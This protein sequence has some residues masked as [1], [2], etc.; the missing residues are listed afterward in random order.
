VDR[1]ENLLR[2]SDRELGNT[3]S[4]L[5]V[6]YSDNSDGK[7]AVLDFGRP[8]YALD[9]HRSNGISLLSEDRVDSLYDQ[10]EIQADFRHQ[11][12]RYSVFAGISD[13]LHDG[14]VRRYKLGLA[15]DE[16][17][18]GPGTDRSLPPAEL[19]PDRKF[20]YPYFE[21]ELLEDNF[22]ETQNHDRIGETEDRYLGT[23]VDLR[24][25]YASRSFGSLSDALLLDT[26]ASVGFGSSESDSL[27]TSAGLHSRIETG[28]TRDALFDFGA[29]YHH[30]HSDKRLLHVA[31]TGQVGHD[32]DLDHQLLLGGDNGL[33]GYPLRYQGGDGSAL[34]TIEERFF[35]DWYP[36]HLFHV[37]A[38][39]FFDAGRTWG[40]NPVGG[41]NLG[42][43]KDVGFGLRF[44]NTR[45]G[46]GRVVHLDFAFPLDGGSDISDMQILFKGKSSF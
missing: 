14:W 24:V 12:D 18:F 5:T 25:G 6:S 36:F 23:R 17:R 32:L 38:A 46:I 26:M 16:D 39:V 29:V 19:P 3:R 27:L 28:G 42:L 35:T 43:L 22:E 45:S 7:R 10:G 1:D 33:R 9:S 41:E 37:G 40:H 15:Y 34:F 31:L 8:F 30:R 21:W 13:G 4:G 44:G 11:V 20:V 2:L